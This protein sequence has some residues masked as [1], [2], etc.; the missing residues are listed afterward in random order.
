[1]ENDVTVIQHIGELC[2]YLTAAKATEEERHHI[3]RLALGNGLDRNVWETFLN[4]FGIPRI[5][6]FYAATEANVG[7]VNTTGKVGAIGVLS[8]LL[9]KKHPGKLIRF[10]F[11]I[12]QPIR[13]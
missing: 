5:V 2:R 6:E 3:V 7:L 8:P 4:R 9:K 1:M 13:D 10:D 12:G 11:E